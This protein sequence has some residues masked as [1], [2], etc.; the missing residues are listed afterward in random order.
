MQC[1]TRLLDMAYDGGLLQTF[2]NYQDIEL[3]MILAAPFEK[4]YQRARVIR[5]F[6]R[7]PNIAT[8]QV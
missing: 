5:K 2:Q 1:I 7:E 6:K 8:F 3:G 4:K